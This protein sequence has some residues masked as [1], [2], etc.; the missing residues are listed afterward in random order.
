MKIVLFLGAGASKFAGMPDTHELV[1]AVKNQV[2]NEKWDNRLVRNLVYATVTEHSGDDVEKLY[3]T[4]SNR[5]DAEIQHKKTVAC[6]MVSDGLDARK[7]QNPGT[8]TPTSSQIILERD[9]IDEN[10][11]ALK[12]L[13]T[14]IRN[15]LLANLMVKP[16]H[17]DDVV[18]TYNEL[19]RHIKPLPDVVTTNYDNVLETY[20]ERKKIGLVNGFSK[21]YLGDRRTWD[22][23][24]QSQDGA[25]RVRKGALR[26]VKLHGSITWQMDGDGTVLE[27]GRPG[28]RDTDRDVMINPTLGAKDYSNDIFP[29]LLDKFKKILD[30]TELL[31]VVGFSFRDDKINEMI[32]SRLER[33]TKNTKPMRLLYVGP[34]PDDPESDGLRKFVEFGGGL[35]PKEVPHNHGLF[36]YSLGSMPYVHA[37]NGRFEQAASH[38]KDI[39]DNM[40]RVCGAL[41]TTF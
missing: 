6:K 8:G 38:M 37:Y 17:T 9:D 34:K 24:G 35:L 13:R 11:L 20:C 36:N 5:I 21:S 22:V 4:I 19:F 32:R 14:T 31:I 1:D 40:D 39:L 12:T 41:P 10:I 23:D 16:E 25:W 18:S 3:Q 29:E 27:I 7:L 15:T 33:T 26:L 28:L 2:S 30:K